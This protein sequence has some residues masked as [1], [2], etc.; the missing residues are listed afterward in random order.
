MVVGLLAVLKAGGAYLPLDP[1][2]PAERLAFMLDDSQ[3]SVLLTEEEQLGRLLVASA[4]VVCLDRDRE[5]IAGESDRNV[6]G[7]ATLHNLAYVIYTSGS[8]G[9]PKGA[10]IQHVGLANYLGWCARAYDV[11]TGQGAPV[12]SSISFD[13][14][15]TALLAPLIVGRRVD[16]L[17]EDLGIEQLSDAL[18][19]SRDYSLVKITPAHLRCLGDQTPPSDAGGRTRAFIIGGEQLLPEHISFWRQ[20]APETALIN[21]Y[22]PTETVVG[23]CVY[24][25]PGDQLLSGRIPIGRPIPNMRLYVLNGSLEPVP[26]GV[27]GEL[28]IGGAGVARGYLHRPRVTAERFIPDRFGT[29]P[30]GRLYRSGDLARWRTDGNLEYLGRV[31]RQV[32]VRGY[33]IEPEEIEAALA[34]HAAVREVAVVALAD[35]TGELTLA[36]YVVVRD[37]QQQTYAA[38][39]RLWLSGVVPEYM[40]PSAFVILESLPLTA[41]GKVDQQALPDPARARHTEGAEFVPPRGR[42]EEIVASIW[43]ALLGREQVGAHDNFFHLGGHS[44][45]ATQIISRLRTAF[46]MEIPLRTLFELPTVS[47]LA[48]WIEGKACEAAHHDATPI[49]PAQRIAT[50]PLSFSQEALWFLDQLAPGQPTFNVSAALRITGPLDEGALKRSINKLVARHESLRTSFVAT[51]GTPHQSIAEDLGLDLETIDLRELPPADREAEAKRLAIA[52]SR[53]PFNL[54][55]GPLARVN[56]LRLDNTDHAVV[57]TMH[58]LVTDGWSFTL[59]GGELAALYT[60]DLERRPSLLPPPRIQYADFTRWQRD[61]FET[62]AWTTQIE[63]WRRRLAGVPPLE[64]PTDHPRPPIRSARGQLY[65]LVLSPELSDSVRALS[66]REGTTPFMTLLAAFQL[67]L[68]RWSGQEDFAVGSPV[69]NR[70]RR[71]TEPVIGYF[72]NMVALRAD[73]SGNP[74]VRE[75]L[76]R[77]R[78]VTLEAVENQEIPLEILIPAVNPQ[79]DASRSALFQV[80]F[81]LQNNPHPNISSLGLALAPLDRDHGTG[82]SKF[83]LSLGFEDTAGGFSGSVEFSTDLFEAQTIER[84]SHQYVKLL[85]TLGADPERRLSELWPLSDVERRQVLG[86]SESHSGKNQPRAVDRRQP[87][88]IHGR[89]EAQARQTP[90]GLALVTGTERLTYAELNERANRLAHH[91]RLRGVGPEV[92]VALVLDGAV[93]RIVAVLATLKAGGAYVP[94]EPSMP[95]ARLEGLLN[96]GRASV[97]IV[98]RKALGQV[99]RSSATMINLDADR[100]SIDLQS[101]DDPLVRVD[102][103]NLAYMVFTSGT[104]GRPKGVMVS[105]RSLLTIGSAW[106]EC[107]ELRKAPLRHLQVAGFAFDVYTG[108]WVRALTTGGILVA[109]PQQV[110]LDPRALA[111]WIHREQIQCVE[112]VPAVAELLAEELERSGLDLVWLRLLV[113]GSDTLRTGLYCRLQRLVGCGARVVN[114]YGLTEATIDST[115]FEGPLESS[116]DEGSVPIGRPLPGVRAYVLDGRGE[117]VHLSVVGELFLGGAGVARGYADAPG[118]TAERFVPDPNGEPGSRMYATGDRARWRAG[119]VLELL[120]RRDGQVKVR[121]FRVEL[122]EIE[123]AIDSFPGIRESA[124]IAQDRGT[125]GQRLIAFIVG[126]TGH[127]VR[128]DAVRRWLRE[129]LPG[130]MIPSHFHIVPNLPRT[131]SGKVDRRALPRSLPETS[132]A[133]Q[134]LVR[135]RNQVEEQLVEIWEDL[136][137]LRPIGVTD[138]FFDKGGH[139]LMAVKLAARIDERF[140]R[141]IALSDLLKGSTIEAIAARLNVPAGSQAGSPLVELGA[142]GPGRP[143]VLVHPIG[144]GVFCYNALARC[145]DGARPVVGMQAPGLEIDTEPETDLVRMASRYV[146]ALR[147]ECPQGPY[148]LGG[149]SMGGVVAF[150]MARQL[151]AAGH[152]VPIVFLIDCSL[153]DGKRVS[154]AFDDRDSW[155]A[156]AADLARTKGPDAKALL[157]DLR[158]LEAGLFRDGTFERA[159]ARSDFAAEIGPDRLRRLHDVFRANRMALDSYQPGSYQGRVVL[160]LAAS[161]TDWPGAD[162]TRGW[163]AL[164]LG[165]VTTYRLPGD[166]YAIIE[167]PGVVQLADILASEVHRIEMP[168]G[169]FSPS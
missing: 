44:L 102:R 9:R 23:C 27:V 39:L 116:A 50:V 87:P 124:V 93:D 65:P 43:A 114:S 25:V 146:D 71:E 121:G 165:G 139:S 52:E 48:K 160:I 78:D 31:D 120:G 118:P 46:G 163:R 143:L 64:L 30:G 74:T 75:L 101:S 66:L 82:T 62:G 156:F 47:G 109:C 98:D 37:G 113:V 32:K 94:L 4:L 13:L 110:A 56:L 7:G 108:D 142:T 19:R 69:A 42:V 90:G 61:Q 40:I 152:E 151:A 169:E 12:H 145:L 81:V 34:R 141:S 147:L 158:G 68:G 24:R 60:A 41:N 115:W 107:Y 128:V 22:G 63:S 70:T 161:T 6:P 168:K 159:I 166:H 84:L 125:G 123:A 140:G 157:D 127:T 138:D 88:G 58:H 28:Y 89:F 91:L 15:I 154:D 67:L 49:Q 83:D 162:P 144:G 148:V 73:L 85:E 55:H 77:V 14:T 18:R 80:M 72:V 99:P 8:T 132:G 133:A 95:A 36:A 53:R 10:M 2:Y 131:L 117:P 33:R 3:A 1:A 104:T 106:E 100:C 122:A 59:A 167:R 57:L 20:H 130:P 79:R 38:E 5:K 119:G 105:H 76:S 149:W 21:E 11:A 92:R 137:Q 51:G 126:E 135:P 150:E 16:L 155:I 164:A 35:A 97:M 26:V 54:A 86:W 29:E 129:R 111:A 96:A 153:P 45:L 136:L 103:D 134:G 112:L 17:D